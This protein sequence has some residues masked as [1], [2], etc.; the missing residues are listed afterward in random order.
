MFAYYY[1]KII[2]TLTKTRKIML[3]LVGESYKEGNEFKWANY[4]IDIVTEEK[5]YCFCILC[6]LFLYL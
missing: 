6:I 1:G 3:R 4:K 2:E 5:S